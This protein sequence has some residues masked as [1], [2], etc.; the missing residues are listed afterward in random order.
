MHEH[1]PGKRWEGT[2][3]VCTAERNTLEYWATHLT[4]EARRK[5]REVLLYG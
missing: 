1:G 3:Y 5:L 4:P 2:R